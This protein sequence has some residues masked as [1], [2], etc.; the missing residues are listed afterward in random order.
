[1]LSTARR[2]AA[3]MLPNG[4]SSA[5][6]DDVYSALTS[7]T[8]HYRHDALERIA[9][10]ARTHVPFYRRL[11]GQGFES[12][13]VV[14]KPMMVADRSQ[15]FDRRAD[16][17]RLTTRFSSG[18]S[19]ISYVSYFDADRISHHRAEMV[20]VH[21]YLGADPF[22]TVVHGTSWLDVSARTK[23]AFCLQ[24]KK[25]YT[26]ESDERSIRT[27]AKWLRRRRGTIIVALCSYLDALFEGFREF[28]IVFD[29]GVIGAVL[30]IG[31]PA[32]SSLKQL[33]STHAGVSLFMRYSNTENGI[34]GISNGA[35]TRYTLNTSTFHFEIL[36]LDS[37]EPVRP[38]E[39]G[40]IVVT[41]LHNRASPYLRY[42]TGDL[43]RFAFDENGAAN[44]AIL[45]ELRGRKRDFPIGGTAEAPRRLLYMEILEPVDRMPDIRQFQLRQNDFGKFTWVLNAP[46]SVEIEARLRKLLDESVGDIVSCEFSYDCEEL[47]VGFGKRQHFINEMPDPELYFRSGS[48]R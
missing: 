8:A 24:G 38:G 11:P 32:T 48:L 34:F 3:Q 7:P 45:Q 9:Q 10:H 43:G 28:D 47:I 26:G 46:R 20:A 37:D 41:D 21:R 33:V 19:G 6:V 5:V 25:M 42:D 13:P 1:M 27:I 29:E 23:L 4:V 31:E 22:A 39:I 36:Q 44:P 2:Y 35:L 14:T 18:T 30:G 16:P 17:D 40:R 12:L 15:F